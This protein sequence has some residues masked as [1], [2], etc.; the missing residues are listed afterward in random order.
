MARSLLKS[1]GGI[2]K[3]EAPKP[4]G[5]PG[6]GGQMQPVLDWENA[7]VVINFKVPPSEEEPNPVWQTIAF[8][9]EAVLDWTTQIVGRQAQEFQEKRARLTQTIHQSRRDSGLLG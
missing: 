7:V 4:A 9:M 5:T 8:P 1:L 6:A 3:R 2:L